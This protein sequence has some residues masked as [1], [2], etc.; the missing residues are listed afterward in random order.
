[1]T[2][3]PTSTMT[4]IKV[5]LLLLLV[6]LSLAIR[7]YVH[8]APANVVRLPPVL[9]PTQAR[10]VVSLQLGLDVFDPLEEVDNKVMNLFSSGSFVRKGSRNVLLLTVGEDVSRGECDI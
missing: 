3:S 10:A 8:P 9:S 7:V 2:S 6:E 1:M 5:W 4:S